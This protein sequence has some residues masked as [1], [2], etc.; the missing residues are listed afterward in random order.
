MN[1]RDL[2]KNSPAFLAIPMVAT[3]AHALAAAETPVMRK[4]AE[5]KQSLEAW[6]AD[7]ERDSSDEN[8]NRWC[9]A[10]YK[11]AD[12]ILD[13]PSEGPMDFIYKLMTYTFEG[14]HEIGSGA[15]RRDM[16]RGPRVGRKL[17]FSV[18]LRS[19]VASRKFPHLPFSDGGI[20]GRKIIQRGNI[21]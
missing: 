21:I 9:E 5:W 19:G 13:I 2:M 17:K 4:Y 1:R 14:D 11:L 15:R 7:M 20:A 16:G 3:A 10:T 8:G 12:K 18:R 6:K